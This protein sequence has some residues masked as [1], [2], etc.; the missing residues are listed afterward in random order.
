MP[1]GHSVRCL[2]RFKEWTDQK[3]R[4]SEICFYFIR[5]NKKKECHGEKS[6]LNKLYGNGSAKSAVTF[7]QRE[8]LNFDFEQ[9]P[10][11]TERLSNL[12][13]LANAEKGI[14]LIKTLVLVIL[15]YDEGWII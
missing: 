1:C 2:C 7:D 15:T 12:L 11:K 10:T 13:H 8:A 3:I 9:L 5:R 4:K 6:R 14:L